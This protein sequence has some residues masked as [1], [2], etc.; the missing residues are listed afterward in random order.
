M[1]WI[2]EMWWHCSG[3]WLTSLDS[4]IACEAAMGWHT[5]HKDG[6]FTTLTSSAPGYRH[7]KG[8]VWFLLYNNVFFLAWNTLG[9][10]LNHERKNLLDVFTRM[11]NTQWRQLKLKWKRMWQLCHFFESLTIELKVTHSSSQVQ[12]RHWILWVTM[13]NFGWPHFHT[14]I[15]GTETT[16]DSWHVEVKVK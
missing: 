5:G 1:S 11:N 8:L 14:T 15:Y 10:I 3:A 13:S 6:Q 7:S 16:Q 2:Q 12:T 9:K 4:A